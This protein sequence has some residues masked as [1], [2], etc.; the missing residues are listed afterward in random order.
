MGHPA[1]LPGCMGLPLL[2]ETP[3]FLSNVFRFLDQRRERHGPVFKSHVLGRRVAFLSG[4]EGAE[5]FYQS[6]NITRADAHPYPFVDLFG[7]INM[8]M[9]DGPR[10]FALKS[11][12]LS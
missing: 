4:I 3:A 1:E 11:M 10:H 7:G 5:T 8:E 12:A 6:E 2:G 9:Y